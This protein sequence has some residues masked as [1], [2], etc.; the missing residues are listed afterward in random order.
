M[1]VIDNYSFTNVNGVMTLVYHYD[2][3]G[4]IILPIING[5]VETCTFQL[6]SYGNP[7][8]NLV[9]SIYA[10]TGV[11]GADAVPTGSALASSDAINCNTIPTYP[12]KA[13]VVFTF[14][15]TNQIILSEGV[16][17]A[18][19]LNWDNVG[20]FTPDI[21]IGIHTNSGRS[22]NLV[23]RD[24]GVWKYNINQDMCFS[25]DG[26]YIKWMNEPKSTSTWSN[27]EKSL[28]PWKD[29]DII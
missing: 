23:Y 10:I 27:N 7:T 15:G 1:A 21:Y 5:K 19:V 22:G 14:S 11:P 8:G 9:A 16:S 18:L 29:N 26:T 25:L 6:M 3:A 28:Q 13:D 17:Y 24:Q 4:Q 20:G 2:T 12:T